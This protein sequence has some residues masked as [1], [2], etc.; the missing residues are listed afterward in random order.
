[1]STTDTAHI[2]TA[3]Y[4]TDAPADATPAPRQPAY[5]F[6]PANSVHH[7]AQTTLPTT[8][9]EELQSIVPHLFQLAAL[10]DAIRSLQ[11]LGGEFLHEEG[12]RALHV[13]SAK[14]LFELADCQALSTERREILHAIGESLLTQTGFEALSIREAQLTEPQLL[15]VICGPV[16]TWRPKTR[17]PLHSFVASVHHQ[18]GASL[19]DQID[20][21][22]EAAVQDLDRELGNL[23]LSAG[24]I[25]PMLVDDLIVC[26][27]ETNT[28]PKH[29]TYFIPEDVGVYGTRDNKAI[30]LANVYAARYDFISRPLG[31]ALLDPIPDEVDD[32][33]PILLTYIR[34]HDV[35]HMMS[36]PGTAY[37]TWSRDLGYEPFMMLQEAVADV[38]G[39]L[40]SLTPQWQSV[41]KF[42]RDS[43]CGVYIA[44]LLH[45]LR[46]GP[47]LFGDA[48]AA[49]LELTF[50]LEHG[51]LQIS[52]KNG[53]IV[54]EA[55]AFCDGMQ[56]LARVLAGDV[57]GAHDANGARLLVEQYGWGG[58]HP[59]SAH[60]LEALQRQLGDVPTSLAY[61]EAAP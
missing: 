32:V 15:T 20:A 9:P 36:V 38:Y 26:G 8:V 23:Q 13:L 3:P 58:E 14:A 46:R 39:F 50:L 34:G 5:R 55:A 43:F 25:Y 27:G 49:Y 45:Y 24:E 51:Y 41:G 10:A 2:P 1:M 11:A 31:R 18:L 53:R 54:W 42:S 33:E 48:G 21:S 29:F 4:E 16:C 6:W 44:E 28:F 37:D 30:V 47:W 12:A 60:V 40:L 59:A 61:V 7:I 57:V 17:Q 52:P 19:I 56:A 22:F 35:G